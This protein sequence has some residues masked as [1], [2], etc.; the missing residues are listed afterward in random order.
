MGQE[1]ATK[2]NRYGY[3]LQ[4][5]R[6]TAG[7]GEREKIRVQ[8]G[9]LAGLMEKGEYRGIGNHNFGGRERAKEK[10]WCR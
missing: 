5:A 9:D 3:K 7:W 2:R 10:Q 4:L 8:N 1:G 6:P